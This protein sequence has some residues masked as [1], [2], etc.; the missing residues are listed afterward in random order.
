MNGDPCPGE[1]NLFQVGFTDKRYRCV[2][3]DG[4]KHRG[5]ATDQCED[6]DECEEG[7]HNCQQD[8]NSECKNEGGSF[9]CDC[10]TGFEKVGGTCKDVDECQSDDPRRCSHKSNMECINTPGS[11]RCKCFRGFT[12]HGKDC[13]CKG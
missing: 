6:I 4:Y 10:K 2:C 12:R 11:F 13:Q 8:E 7:I 1:N 3:R 9:R 5:R